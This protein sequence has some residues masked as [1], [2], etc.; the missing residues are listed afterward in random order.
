MSR[1]VELNDL[2]EDQVQDVIDLMG[3]LDSTIKVTPEMVRRMVEVEG[4]HF[5][6]V[7][8]GESIVGCASLCVFDS[9][10][11][12]KASV[13]D[14][15]VSSAFRGQ[16]L[17]KQLMQHVIVSAKALA[18]INLQLTSR[19][20]RVAANELYQSLGFRKRETNAYRMEIAG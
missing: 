16:R 5:F 7:M 12:R 15:V 20:E 2:T 3:E 1:V 13:E 19:P 17:G 14:V 6:A 11:G 10:T 18:P 9:P 4:T 8:E